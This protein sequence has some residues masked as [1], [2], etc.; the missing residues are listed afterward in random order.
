MR[1]LLETVL[2]ELRGSWRFR[3]LAVGIAWIACLIGWAVV[4]ALPDSYEAEATVLIDTTSELRQLLDKMTV[5]PDALTQVEMVR[6]A[7]L[8][9]DQLENVARETDLHLRLRE[10]ESMDRLVEDIR[11]RI[12]IDSERRRGVD[13]NLYRLA[14]S[15]T[16]PGKAFAVVQKLL[17]NFV[18]N[19][20][21][22]NRADTERAQTFLREQIAMLETELTEAERRLADFKRENVG[23][24]PGERGDYFQ[25]LQQEMDELEATRSELRQARRQ[26][27]ALKRQL[28]GEQPTLSSGGE[29]SELEQRI[30]ENARRLEEL[31]LRFTD[32]H[33][34]VIAVKSTLDQLRQQKQE[35]IAKL[36]SGGE[37]GIASDNPVFQSI[38]I[39]L[40]KIEVAIA[41]LE[42]KAGSHVRK[43]EELQNL[44]DVLP[45]IEAELVRLNRDYSVKQAQYQSLLQRLEVAELS[46]SAEKTE[47]VKFQ[48]VDAPLEPEEPAF[49]NRPLF[50]A[51]VLV[52]GLGLGGGVA[53][54][55]NQLKPVF[56]SSRMVR[57]IT[58]LPV[59]GTVQ[60]IETKQRRRYQLAQIAAFGSA[61]GALCAVFIVVLLFDD[62]GSAQLRSLI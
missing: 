28:A 1:E 62:V 6:T 33:P 54:L 58:G 23:R 57:E 8:G 55:A 15:D 18:E 36:Q 13:V 5:N 27:D 40:G 44:V 32:K 3:W 12:T 61:V 16:D 24:M 26:R 47:D 41:A 45:Q 50:L 20:L 42:E 34:D 51:G 49:P 59:L 19:T 46:E 35:Q 22:I 14:Y 31:Q 48:V 43:I 4:Y 39:E 30:A 52:A 10:G 29:P 2:A 60:A 7:L 25:R 37:A 53:F 11:S 17:D 21:G 9:R 56:T 38:Q